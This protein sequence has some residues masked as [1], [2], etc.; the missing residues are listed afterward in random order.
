MNGTVYKTQSIDG[1]YETQ[2]NSSI[3]KTRKP[4]HVPASIPTAVHVAEVHREQDTSDSMEMES[5]THC[6]SNQ[7]FI[8]EDTLA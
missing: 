2:D 1:G 6:N 5:I 4:T 3:H 7:A 8:E